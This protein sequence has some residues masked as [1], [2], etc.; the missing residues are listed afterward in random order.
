ML[1]MKDESANGE[2]AAQVAGLEERLSD[3]GPTLPAD[4]A[5]LPGDILI[6]GAG[7]KIGPNLVRMALRA[8]AAAG[9]RRRVF[10]ASRFSDPA[11]ARA[12]EAAG[13]H[14]ERIDLSSPADL[15]RL[16]DA[17]NVVFLVSAR[18][19][20]EGLEPSMW[21]TNAFMP[22]E[23]VRRFPTSRLVALSSGNVYPLSAVA[24]GGSTEATPVQPVGEYGMSCLG[25]ERVMM[26]LAQETGA[27][28]A[29]LRL[30]YAVEMRY[31]PL[32]DIA[33]AVHGGE[34][35]H[36]GMG[37][38]NVVWQ[39][40]A[41]EV[42]LRALSLASCPGVVLNVAGPETVSIR[43]LALR[44]GAHLG[45]PVT[46]EGEEAATALLS[47]AERCHTLYGY[48]RVT[49]G[50]LIEDTAAWVSAGLPLIGR[51]SGFQKRDG[52]F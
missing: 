50:Q 6:L 26:Q 30:N 42:I 40:Y 24:Q 47:N 51:G 8:D 25:R 39:G 33:R 49:L 43:H 48:P 41:N 15:A 34:K 2:T 21:R 29:V 45:R 31:G 27:D 23:V 20:M 35:V 11:K 5:S 3:P 44:L 16:P 52:K 28:L 12:L 4:L 1:E 13:A 18:F 14:I 22:G 46:F 38:V 32:V 7:G 9:V 36:L 17:E 37:L 19:G 10:A